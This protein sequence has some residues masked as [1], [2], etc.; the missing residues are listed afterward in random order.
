MQR[1]FLLI[2]FQTLAI[3]AYM[4]APGLN[5]I[6]ISKTEDT[7]IIDGKL[8]E[9]AWENARLIDE[10]WQHWPNDTIPAEAKT[11]VRICYSNEYIYVG[12]ICYEE[13]PDPVVLSMRRDDEG[14]YWR[15]DAFCISIDPLNNDKSG[16]IFGLNTQ[17]VQLD[18]TLSQRGANPYLD[19]FWD[20]FWE[21]EACVTEKGYV[22]EI[23]IPFT[24][25][26][27][28]EDNTDWGINF[29][30]NDMKRAAYD[31]WS[32]FPMA[33]SGL[34]FGYNGEVYFSD[35]VPE[36]E[37]GR[38]V[39][40]PSLSGAVVR[41]F[42][43]GEALKGNIT[44]GLD[45]K[46]GIGSDL[47]LDLSIYPDFSTVNVDQ[48]YIDFY[49]FE[50]FLPE[51]RSFFLENGDLFSGFGS[52]SDHT[53]VASD[54]RIKPLYTRRIGIYDWNYV[55]MT[56]GVRL[57][58][59][60]SEDVRIG[61]FNVLN[62]P[63]E[64]RPSQNYSA[65]SFQWGIFK[66]S[67]IKGV[68]TNRQS[69]QDGI[70]FD[71]NDYNRTAGVEFDY[72]NLTGS[73]TGSAK[74]HH[75]FNPENY[76]KGY[77][78]GGEIN[79]VSKLLKVNTKAYQVGNNYIADMGFVPRLYHK[80]D[81]DDTEFR[82]GFMEFTNFTS[83]LFNP[84]GNTFLYVTPGHRF[85]VFVNP[86]GEMSDYIGQLNL[87]GEF[88]GRSAFNIF[89]NYE[90][91]QLLAPRDILKNDKPLDTGTYC[92][93]SGGIYWASDARKRFQFSTT[94]EYGT[95]YSGKRS[96]AHIG[97]N[98]RVQPWGQFLFGYNF[99]RLDFPE[100]QGMENYHLAALTTEIT[101][102]K[103]V[104]W[105]SLIQYNTQKENMNINSMI[106]WRFRSMSDFFIVVK[107]DFEIGSFSNKRFQMNFKIR[108]WL[109]I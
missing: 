106:R 66:R 101:F 20:E 30:R 16:Y 46:M 39:L 40:I 62:E 33:F 23:A 41:N 104:N 27:F 53:T 74:Y 31:I 85:S 102:S 24:S 92:Y 59:N 70:R 37:G 68:F 56:Y 88:K 34:D 91:V 9:L 99:C 21:G 78:V 72:M 52:Y 49:R 93:Q 13:N 69:V 80:N 95:F 54:N 1:I 15:S 25:I 96:S 61:V 75:S 81:L 89:L 58:G 105:T 2:V 51:M 7:F 60:V 71:V 98:Y 109:N 73:W 19:P 47:S 65:A 38:I 77:F 10:F 12:A 64:N 11:E 86:N 90:Q 32:C 28:N 29:I 87:Y 17:G 103:N 42:E 3:S 108:Y 43:E 48:Q 4:Q 18:G 6:H 67:A 35:E 5:R 63:Y 107:E 8:E 45:A 97:M 55:P 50:Y 79:Y 82:Q 57:S 83:M 94:L 84:K 76:S 100:T 14:N 36:Q 44:G 22:Y 26:K